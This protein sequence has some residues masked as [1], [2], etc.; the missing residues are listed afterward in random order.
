MTWITASWRSFASLSAC[1][2]HAWPTAMCVGHC[3]RAG[4]LTATAEV[5][6]ITLVRASRDSNCTCTRVGIT[7]VGTINRNL[8]RNMSGNT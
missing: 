4:R 1:A 3:N 7:W 6:E 8:T 2:N 5:T